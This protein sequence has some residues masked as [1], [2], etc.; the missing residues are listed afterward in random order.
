M[1]GTLT[2]R[3]SANKYLTLLLEEARETTYDAYSRVNRHVHAAKPCLNEIFPQLRIEG[4]DQQNSIPHF[5]FSGPRLD[6]Y[7]AGPSPWVTAQ[8]E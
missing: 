4:D 3:L 8:T 5:L 6:G 1:Y 2:I 7:G